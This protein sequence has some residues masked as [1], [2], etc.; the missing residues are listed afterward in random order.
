MHTRTEGKE[1]NA[2][3]L[4]ESQGE[5]ETIPKLGCHQGEHDSTLLHNHILVLDKIEQRIT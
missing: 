1:G 4:H 2:L 3:T 5:R